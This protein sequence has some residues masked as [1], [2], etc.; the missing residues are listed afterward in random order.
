MAFPH[1]IGVRSTQL[2]LDHSGWAVKEPQRTNE[3]IKLNIICAIFADLNRSFDSIRPRCRLI[4]YVPINL[5][6]VEDVTELAPY[7][8]ALFKIASNYSI[9]HLI[10]CLRSFGISRAILNQTENSPHLNLQRIAST[11]FIN[12]FAN[13][14]YPIIFLN[15]RVTILNLPA[16]IKNNICSFLCLNDLIHLQQANL[17]LKYRISFSVFTDFAKKHGYLA[18]VGYIIRTWVRAKND[19]LDLLRMKVAFKRF[20]E[21]TDLCHLQWFLLQLVIG[22][23]IDYQLLVEKKK[24]TK[25]ITDWIKTFDTDDKAFVNLYFRAKD[26]NPSCDYNFARNRIEQNIEDSDL[27]E[28]ADISLFVLA[29]SIVTMP[30]E[31][32]LKFAILL[33]KAWRSLLKP[34]RLEAQRALRIFLITVEEEEQDGLDLIGKQEALFRFMFIHTDAATIDRL[35]SCLPRRMKKLDLSMLSLTKYQLGR[36]LKKCPKL[37]YLKLTIT[38]ELDDER[39]STLRVLYPA[40]KIDWIILK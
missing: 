14:Y 19:P 37:T 9:A 21:E 12:M 30:T 39:M 24:F 4:V 13:L 23:V 8:N 7:M 17:T 5:L 22:G 16:A 20:I 33:K 29:D 28:L 27:K 26:P 1:S 18:L 32:I 15:S 36:I 34:E 38:P 40:L 3:E 10:P 25:Q 6:C 35:I 2:R 11:A 31:A